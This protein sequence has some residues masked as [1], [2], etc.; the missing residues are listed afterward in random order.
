MSQYTSG[1]LVAGTTALTISAAPVST[2]T[3]AIREVLVQAD[4]SN[5]TNVLVGNSSAQPMVLTPG[6]AITVP[7]I[8]LS[9]IWA[10]M[11]SGEGSLNW[12][13]RD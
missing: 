9:L 11:A 8:S 7:V 5:S 6:Q 10:K 3:H 12:F 4:P 2:A 1:R 13:G